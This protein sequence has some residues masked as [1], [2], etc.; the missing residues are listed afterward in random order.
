MHSLVLT[1]ADKRL[2]YLNSWSV[3]VDC[4]MSFAFNGTSQIWISHQS[5]VAWKRNVIEG[6]ILVFPPERL[7]ASWRDLCFSPS[8]DTSRGTASKQGYGIKASKGFGVVVSPWVLGNTFLISSVS[9]CGSR[10]HPLIKDAKQSHTVKGGKHSFKLIYQ[11][12]TA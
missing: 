1:N 5:Q 3:M 9:S 10:A 4:R 2:V 11:F 12:N 6:H 7:I 8:V